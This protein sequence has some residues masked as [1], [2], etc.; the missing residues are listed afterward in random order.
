MNK[1][2]TR[3][4]VRMIMAVLFAT[5][6]IT[7]ATTQPV[8]S[9]PQTYYVNAK[10][11]DANDG[12]TEETA[13]RSLGKALEEVSSDTRPT[14]IVVIGTLDSK[15]DVLQTPGNS[16]FYI[17]TEGQALITIRGK[18]DA[19]EGE[20]AVLKSDVNG[21]RVVDII[22]KSNICFEHIEIS[23]G[24]TDLAGGGIALGDNARL[25]VGEGAFITD[26]KSGQNG[27]GVGVYGSGT[28]TMED[29]AVTNNTAERRGGGI[30]VGGNGTFT[31]KGGAVIN[32]TAEGGGGGGVLI[33]ESGTFTMSEGEITGN[34]TARL[35]G[36]V[37]VGGSGTF[38]MKG[39]A[40]TNNT[41]EAGGGVLIGGSG[42][43]TMEGGDVTNNTAE[44]IG[45]G[46]VVVGGIFTM[47]EGEITGNK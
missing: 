31:M 15:S 27:G 45:G 30:G 14:T 33:V 24:R 26:N 10:G 46:V 4:S 22:G 32:N 11:S 21:R 17:N 20:K 19:V 23:G 5:L 37:G 12:H 9:R 39:G 7:R 2:T 1:Q 18:P 29:G 8:E 28:F 6:V 3:T 34:K 41:A 25:T 35:G 42:T 13:F 36:G 43:F 38:T 40:V 47:S 16:I 44:G